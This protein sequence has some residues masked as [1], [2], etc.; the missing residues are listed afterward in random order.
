MSSFKQ[1]ELKVYE[2]VGFGAMT[3]GL[4]MVLI[5]KIPHDPESFRHEYIVGLHGGGWLVLATGIAWTA[6]VSA[7]LRTRFFDVGA[8]IDSQALGTNLAV[9]G[10]VTVAALVLALAQL[11][12]TPRDELPRN[13]KASADIVKKESGTR[14]LVVAAVLVT[15]GV[16]GSFPVRRYM[17]HG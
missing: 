14:A 4:F 12:S 16:I 15:A 5:T 10:V 1:T 6:L 3:L 9:I 2:R 13:R 17:R 11:P 7:H 8:R